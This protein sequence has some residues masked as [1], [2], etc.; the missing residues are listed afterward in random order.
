M[1]SNSGGKIEQRTILALQL[2]AA[3]CQ[4]G[5]E[6][7]QS[8]YETQHEGS[9]HL[10]MYWSKKEVGRADVRDCNFIVDSAIQSKNSSTTS[11]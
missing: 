10:Q 3:T 2:F 1:K 11:C 7:G 4:V 6:C 5:S 8:D 9:L